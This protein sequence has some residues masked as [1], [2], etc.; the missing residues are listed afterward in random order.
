MTQQGKANAAKFTGVHAQQALQF[1]LL[2]DGAD[3]PWVA[4]TSQRAAALAMGV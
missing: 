4:A 1:R 2:A 3:A